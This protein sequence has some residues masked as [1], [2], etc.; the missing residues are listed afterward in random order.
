VRILGI[1]VALILETQYGPL[2]RPAGQRPLGDRDEEFNV[3]F[4]TPTGQVLGYAMAALLDCAVDFFRLP[5]VAFREAQSRKRL[6]GTPGEAAS[7]E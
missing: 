6:G 2:R 3:L 5:I 7:N 1:F 4:K